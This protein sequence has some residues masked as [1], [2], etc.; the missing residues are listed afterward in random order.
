MDDPVVYKFA[1]SGCNSD[2]GESYDCPI[3]GFVVN[4]STSGYCSEHGG[5]GW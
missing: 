5:S 3:H 4:G 2:I 1:L